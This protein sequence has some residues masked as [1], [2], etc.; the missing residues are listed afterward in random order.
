MQIICNSS[1][2]KKRTI[3]WSCAK[4]CSLSL[5]KLTK[6]TSGKIKQNRGSWEST[7]WNKSGAM[8]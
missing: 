7:W 5:R 2:L 4:E 6:L 1:F 3:H 8:E